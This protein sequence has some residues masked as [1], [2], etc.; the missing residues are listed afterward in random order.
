[1]V[2]SAPVSSLPSPDLPYPPYPPHLPESLP[3]RLRDELGFVLAEAVPIDPGVIHNNRLF[4]L[5]AAGGRNLVAKVYFRDDR[6]RLTREFG[7]FRFLRA[8]GLTSVPVAYFADEAEQYAV[9]SFEPGRTK[10]PSELTLD[11]LEAIGRLAAD[12]H[13]FAPAKVDAGIPRGF[14]A[15]S[16]AQHADILRTRLA[17]S[18][19]AAAA[20]DAYEP[21][22]AVVA[23]I[24]LPAALERSIAAATAGLTPV[25]ITAPVPEAYLRL[26]PGDFAP[27]NVL[28]RPDG[29]PCAIDFEYA[30]WEGPTMVPVGFLAA[31]QSE[32]LTGAQA[33]AFLHTYHAHRDVPDAAFGRFDRLR[34]LAEASWVLVN[35]SLMTPTHV[36]RKRFAGDF[37]L[38]V[39]LADRRRRLE[40]RLAGLEALIDDLF[41]RD[42]SRPDLYGEGRAAD[43]GATP[44]IR[45]TRC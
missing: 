3:A 42:T 18:L 16:L 32:G 34:I 33:N 35:L 30:C 28:V 44:D 22:R 26:N 23:E 5:R 2:S 11:E 41:V 20:P 40:R 37:D 27:H 21:L 4:R 15:G 17:T 45:W 43:C 29:S 9:Y 13:R 36:A 10:P 31:E 12:L 7:A 39:H 6:R 25:E 1:V 24:G 8:R 14:A 38:D 19:D